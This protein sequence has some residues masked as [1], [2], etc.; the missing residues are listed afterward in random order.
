M[1]VRWVAARSAGAVLIVAVAL[2]LACGSNG[3]PIEP[4][5][6]SLRAT[7][8]A[9]FAIEA[10]SSG[11]AV[12]SFTAPSAAGGRAPYETTCTPASG[13]SFP[14]GT[15]NVSCRVTDA[16]G[17]QASCGFA[18]TV[19]VSRTLSRTRFLAFGDS[20]TWGVAALV[21][22]IQLDALDTYPFKLEQMLQERYPTQ[23]FQVVNRGWPGETTPRGAA[24]LP[25]VLNEDRPEVLLLLEG[26]N[27]V[28]GLSANT[29]A[30]SLRTMISAAEQRGVATI[31]ATVM[32]ISAAREAREPGTMAAIRA[33]NTRIYQLAAE[34]RLGPPVDLFTLFESN[35][36]L[37]SADGLHPTLEGQTRIADAFR[38]AIIQ[39][40]E[41]PV[42]LRAPT[43]E[44]TDECC[45]PHAR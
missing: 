43:L 8:P 13:S 41:A 36:Q 7:C 39:R 35:P 9:S 42:S 25:G 2:Q 3:T 40:F 29:Q 20:I 22:M 23:Q 37:I 38:D 31:I 11:G 32:A 44:T 4:G 1:M 21:P 5:G 24:R 33:I 18:V 17:A 26:V 34:Y 12:A 27:N 14:F 15:T 30:S 28:R 10:T 16:G 6:G 19:R 45:A